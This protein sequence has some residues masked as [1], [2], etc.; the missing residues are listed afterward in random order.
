[1]ALRAVVEDVVVAAVVVVVVVINTT[2][3]SC[4]ELLGAARS[5]Q[6]MPVYIMYSMQ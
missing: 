4:R 1:M 2:S 5:C 6:E 3:R